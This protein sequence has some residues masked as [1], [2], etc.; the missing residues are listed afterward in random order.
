[1]KK[2][3]FG[4]GQTLLLGDLHRSEIVNV[5]TERMQLTN[6][7]SSDDISVA[8]LKTK[9]M[10]W[11]RY[12]WKVDTMRP[13]TVNMRGYST[14]IRNGTGASAGN[15]VLALA[16]KPVRNEVHQYKNIKNA[17]FDFDAK[18]DKALALTIYSYYL[19]HVQFPV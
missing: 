11:N 4:E 16:S 8:Q 12:Y 2:H 6:H 17:S 14:I 7:H 9:T 1:M 13:D 10:S 19:V 5:A 3:V 18:W 15:A